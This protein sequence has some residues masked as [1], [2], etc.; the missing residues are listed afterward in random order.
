MTGPEHYREA[1]RLLAAQKV[2]S[3]VPGYGPV[4]SADAD[5]EVIAIAQ[6]HATLALTAAMLPVDGDAWRKAV[7]TP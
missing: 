6:A 7:G 1:E 2:P 5:P 3:S 4:I